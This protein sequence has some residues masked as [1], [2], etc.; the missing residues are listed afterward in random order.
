MATKRR[1]EEMSEDL[2]CKRAKTFTEDEN[3]YSAINILS[4]SDE[5]L[6]LIMMQLPS[7]DLISI[8]R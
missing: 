4:F 6:L 8:S 7:Q 1:I 2:V 3:A 5:I